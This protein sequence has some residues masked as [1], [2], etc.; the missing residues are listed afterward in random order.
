MKIKKP[1]WVWHDNQWQKAV[2]MAQFT[3][4]S[5][6]MVL[7]TLEEFK[8]DASDISNTE[9]K[10]PM[11]KKG[12]KL[13]ITYARSLSASWTEVITESHLGPLDSNEVWETLQNARVR[14][15]AIIKTVAGYDKDYLCGYC[16]EY[17]SNDDS[18]NCCGCGHIN[19]KKWDEVDYP[20]NKYELGQIVD[21]TSL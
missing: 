3:N 21:L 16:E 5:R 1:V 8:A 12:T 17:S 7:D 9:P 20:P 13:A 6:V 10:G 19:W 15:Q 18:I 14:G 11:V 2:V 4:G